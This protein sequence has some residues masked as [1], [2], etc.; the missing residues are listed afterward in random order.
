MSWLYQSNIPSILDKHPQLPQVL[1]DV[2]NLNTRL[3]AGAL[4]DR[5]AAKEAEDTAA[6]LALQRGEVSRILDLTDPISS[7]A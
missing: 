5:R 3:E 1:T 4:I 2:L 7:R 6:V